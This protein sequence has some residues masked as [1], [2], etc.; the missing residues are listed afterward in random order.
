MLHRLLL[1]L[2]IWCTV[3]VCAMCWGFWRVSLVCS[4]FETSWSSIQRGKVQTISPQRAAHR[5]NGR[6]MLLLF[7]RHL[8][9]VIKYFLRIY[10]ILFG[11]GRGFRLSA[12]HCAVSLW[13]LASVC[14][15]S[16]LATAYHNLLCVTYCTINILIRVTCA[17]RVAG[18]NRTTSKYRHTK[19]NEGKKWMN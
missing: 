16:E 3:C 11:R 5:T 1:F 10:F 14:C 15:V 2:A 8:L 7:Y 19:R 4:Q 13:L 17:I 18:T 12:G 9:C 6:W